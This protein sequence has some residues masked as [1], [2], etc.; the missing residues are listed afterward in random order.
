MHFDD[1][2][3]VLFYY[4]EAEN[5]PEIDLHLGRCG[6]CRK[7]FESLKTSLA[8]IDSWQAPA[9]GVEYGE[10]V[11]RRLA[12]QDASIGRRRSRFSWFSFRKM[13]I[14]GAASAMLVAAFLAGRLTKEPADTGIAA[15]PRAVQE[16]LLAASLADHL[17]DSA[18]TLIELSNA[19][20]PSRL[21]EERSRA[22]N[23]L[24][25]NRLY[26]QSAQDHGQ[27]GLASVLDD[28]ERVLLTIARGP[29]Q[30]TET[31]LDQLRSRMEDQALLF[32]I[33]TLELRL[34]DLENRPM[35][36]PN[37]RT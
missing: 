14:V 20:G 36:Q 7:R 29:E 30:P 37:G 9:R 35:R 28:L 33:R 21:I 16:R 3:L 27:R 8:K 25:A 31:Q 17:D 22:E 11:W 13:V 10:Q 15:L 1:D 18:R 34:R 32:K 5:S 6:E 12:Q 2:H 26:R 23:L 19:D 4:G 24:A